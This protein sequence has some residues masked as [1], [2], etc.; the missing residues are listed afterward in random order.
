MIRRLR[1]EVPATSANLGPGY[2]SF[3]L[4][5]GLVDTL[6]LTVHDAPVDPT[7]VVTI[8]GESAAELPRDGSHLIVS[9]LREVLAEIAPDAH[10]ELLPRITL[11]CTNR[12]PHSRGLGSSA[13]AVVA[14]IALAGRLAEAAGGRGLTPEEILERAA[15]IE[16][17][18]DNAA[19]AIFGGL[20]ISLSDP[21]R[22]WNVPVRT[23]SA[24]TVLVPEERLDTLTA[25]GA[26]PAVVDH[27]VAAENAARTGLFVHALTED[28]DALFDATVDRL[29]QEARRSA[30]P[31]SM[32]L[33]DALRS[34]G[35]PA[36]ISGAG[37]TVLALT[38]SVPAEAV[39][40]G[41]RIL[42]VD[43]DEEGCRIAD[44]V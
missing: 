2:D 21:A 19:P 43:I 31:G 17:H 5:L 41:V 30:Y 39:P 35:I 23:L 32:D 37:P 20:T 14:G 36:V 3:G 33:V 10:A 7:A 6:E 8:T 25:R 18:P 12:I 22:A 29:H 13:A 34:R 44:V 42:T 40:P 1:I 16:G 9:V 28:R 15:V 26:I 38:E 11:E 24:V 4:A 27:A